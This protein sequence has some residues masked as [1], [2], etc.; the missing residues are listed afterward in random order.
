MANDLGVATG[1]RAEWDAFDLTTQVGV[2]VEVKSAA[3]IQTW[4]QQDYSKIQFSIA[5]TQAWDAKTGEYA[6]DKK[7]QGDVYVF[8]LLHHKEQASLDP[9]AMD[10]WTFYVLATKVLNKV[11][12]TQKML[13]LS[14]L[15][16]LNPAQVAYGGIGPA[17]E[18]VVCGSE[19]DSI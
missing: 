18:R 3:Y 9:L 10:Q 4:Y 16:K 11:M 17:V 12:P 13:S 8:C 19:A 7:R 15:Q 2:K 6:T 5:P 1:V 14:R